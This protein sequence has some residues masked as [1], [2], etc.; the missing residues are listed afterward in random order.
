MWLRISPLL[1]LILLLCPVSLILAAADP[2]DRDGSNDP[3][4]FSR[5]PGFYINSFQELEF[6]RYE[7]AVNPDKKEAVEGR[8]YTVNYSA[9]DGITQPSGLQVTRNYLNAAKVI[10][11]EKLYEWE[12]GGYQNITLKVVLKDVEVWA[13]I[14]GANN[15]MYSVQLIEKQLMTQDVVANAA[16]MA[17][18]INTTGKVAVYGIYFDTNKAEVKTESEPALQE[19]VKLLQTDAKLKLYVVGHTDNVGSFD[20]NIQLSKDRANAVVST[21]IKK[22]G[23]SSSVLLP[24]GDGPTAPV[25][26]NDAETGRAKNRRVELVKQ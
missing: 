14:S 17:G 4:H 16:S 8:H 5:M 13:E 9:N 21:L 6:D 3:P 18:D 15:G 22:Y 1:L 25:A 11:G 2:N 24:Y 12:D 19:I 10:G 20:H 7:F 26:S 23:I